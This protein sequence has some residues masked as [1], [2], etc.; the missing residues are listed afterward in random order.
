MTN[1]DLVAALETI[2]RYMELLGE[3]GFR[4][5]AHTR[6]AR[7]IEGV[8]DDL[9]AVAKGPDA[10]KKLTELKGIGPAI[11]KKLI[12]LCATGKCAELEEL[13]AK[14]PVGLIPLLQLQ[15]FGPKSV[16]AWWKEAGV[17][18]IAS[19]KAAVESGKI[20]SLPRHSQKTVDKL[21]AA[22]ESAAQGAGRMRLGQARVL[23]D[24]VVE[25][26]KARKEV[27]HAEAAGS[28]RRGR[29]SVGDIDIIVASSDPAA[30]SKAFTTLPMVQSVISAG[31]TR[32]SVKMVALGGSRWDKG[33]ATD[34]EHVVVAGVLDA[35]A[36][37]PSSA[38]SEQRA[39]S[40][41]ERGEGG[42]AAGPTVQVDLRVVP[43]E[44]IGAAMVYFTGSKDHN[45]HLRQRALDMGYTVNDYGVY[46]ED[47]DD[48]TPP[49][50]RKGAAGRPLASKSEADIYA[51]LKLP[52][53]P[54]EIREDRGEFELKETPRLIEVADVKAE[55]HAHTT[56]SDGGL[57]ILELAAAAK[58]RGF[59]TVAVTDHSQ[60]Q[61]QARGLKPDRLR[62]HIAA[63][64]SAK[65]QIEGITILAGS[66]VDILPDGRLDY[67]DELLAELDVVVASPHNNLTQNSADATERLVKAASHPLVH[68]IGHPTGRLV[69]R[70]KGLEP[71]MNAVI[72]AARAHGTAL[73]INAH[74]M[75]LD[76]RDTHVRAAVDAGCV[77]AID[78]DV[79]A[80]SDFD[81]LRYG[82]T[83]ARRGWVTPEVC[84]NTWPAE[85][86]HGWLKKKR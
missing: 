61:F 78:C 6:A 46:V 76:L 16:H 26:L 45:I 27:L 54:P 63:I 24:R 14:V 55:L 66:E 15:G 7:T 83:T 29:D 47:K 62:Q 20:A 22:L 30:T 50:K 23:A 39:P 10:A 65:Q 84:V 67:D 25:Q 81:N 77:I 12:E 82:V 52:Y 3:D 19:L 72:A 2:A 4:I 11:A 73:E 70:R 44:H 64:R 80:E 8:N 75:R 79:H 43:Q 69:L 68:I 31:D 40:P 86:L 48:D 49:H 85:K 71:D 18:D 28:M 35:P 57:S 58:A 33:E 34:D 36:A 17:T 9:V 56:A 60:S 38:R 1:A 74:W 37:N 13:Q 42:A 5:I 59:H 51:F 41:P 32:A 53:I 21:K